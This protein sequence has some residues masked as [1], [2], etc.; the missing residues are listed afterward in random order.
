MGYQ[1]GLQKQ[2]NCRKRK[3]Y[4]DGGIHDEK[5]VIGNDDD[6]PQVQ[7]I[8]RKAPSPLRVS[9][10]SLHVATFNQNNINTSSSSF[11]SGRQN[12]DYDSYHLSKN[13][14]EIPPQ[15]GDRYHRTVDGK[16][17]N[18]CPFCYNGR[19]LWTFHLPEEHK[20]DYEK[21]RRPWKYTAPKDGE[22]HRKMHNNEIYLWCQKCNNGNGVWGKHSTSSHRDTQRDRFNRE[23]SNMSHELVRKSSNDVSCNKVNGN[24]SIRNSNERRILPGTKQSIATKNS[25][26]DISNYNAHGINTHQIEGKTS[27]IKKVMGKS[28]RALQ[29]T[30]KAK[31]THVVKKHHAKLH[32]RR[33]VFPSAIPLKHT[34]KADGVKRKL[35]IQPIQSSQTVPTVTANFMAERD[36][37]E[38]VTNDGIS[39]KTN[40]NSSPSKDHIITKRINNGSVLDRG[41][42]L[43]NYAQAIMNNND[44]TNKIDKNKTDIIGDNANGV[45]DKT[46]THKNE[47]VISSISSN[48]QQETMNVELS[49]KA[50]QK[51]VVDLCSDEESLESKNSN[52]EIELEMNHEQSIDDTTK[53]DT[54]KDDS[55]PNDSDDAE[56][57]ISHSKSDSSETSYS[58]SVETYDSTCN[59]I[60]DSDDLASDKELKQRT[61][62]SDKSNTVSLHNRQWSLNMTDNNRSRSKKDDIN[63]EER[64]WLE[65]KLELSAKDFLKRKDMFS[66][67]KILTTPLN[68]LCKSYLNCHKEMEWPMNVSL[69]ATVT[70]WK[71]KAREYHANNYDMH[72][73]AKAPIDSNKKSS[74]L[75]MQNVKHLTKTDISGGLLPLM[76]ITAMNIH[77][78]KSIY[79]F[80]VTYIHLNNVDLKQ[81]FLLLFFTENLYD[82]RVNIRQ[83]KIPGDSGFGAFLTFLGARKLKAEAKRLSE[84]IRQH[85]MLVEN[86]GLGFVS[87]DGVY[88]TSV[89]LVGNDLYGNGNTS[90]Y[91]KTRFPLE[92]KMSDDKTIAVKL[93]PHNIHESVQELMN[94]Y[95]V[96]I[97]ENGLGLLEIFTEEDYE[98]DNTIKFDSKITGCIDLGRYGPFSQKGMTPIFEK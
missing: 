12:A 14:R 5:K 24:E 51:E 59:D 75:L 78:G 93:T 28:A 38:K 41:S 23:N 40:Q 91:P 27:F 47:K 25:N 36:N 57:S 4:N 87:L 6:N 44:I 16:K 29:S 60:D 61:A 32:L 83:S 64:N 73:Q 70:R 7:K 22:S 71:I 39:P 52:D 85:Q 26:A 54:T 74:H 72:I 31:T 10:Q 43:T 88:N 96:K 30:N 19:G 2:M 92:A 50:C 55:L 62:F 11:R 84:Q 97:Q 45:S 69:L 80:A 20:D 77:N 49:N 34:S 18:W 15:K 82:F 65:S 95:E 90:H 68:D 53:D 17:F 35:P 81:Q 37:I 86:D 46:S 33:D 66:I 3:D 76:K 42:G 94:K 58:E 8:P 48:S 56:D 9:T 67:S 1:S 21:N 79:L 13:W 63:D 89:S 98:N